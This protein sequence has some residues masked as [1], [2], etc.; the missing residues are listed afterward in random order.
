MIRLALVDDHALVRQ[1]LAQLL[2]SA[3]DIE[4]VGMGASGTD[5]VRL[6]EDPHSAPD[7]LLM[8]LE[9]PHMDGIEATRRIV[10]TRPETRIVILT[11]FADRDRILDALDAGATGY[12]LKDAEPAELL[13][14]VRA[15]AGGHSPL[16]P[17]AASELLRSRRLG[18]PAVELSARERDVLRLVGEGLPNKVIGM[19]LGIAEK[20]VKSHL[21]RIFERIGV[22][23][24]TQAALWVQRNGLGR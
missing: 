6:V 8:D 7:V 22:S 21:T 23:D 11:S 3:D 12:L 14:G 24:R 2:D 9:M 19:R 5:A 1:G 10:A 18:A 17:R 13:R 4:L 20:T 16:A 15:A